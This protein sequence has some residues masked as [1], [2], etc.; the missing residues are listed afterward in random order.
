MYI[1]ILRLRLTVQCSILTAGYNDAMDCLRLAFPAA[2]SNENEV[3]TRKK[4]LHQ[5]INREKIFLI[6]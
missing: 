2:I 1:L 3:H 5:M 6:F 4:A